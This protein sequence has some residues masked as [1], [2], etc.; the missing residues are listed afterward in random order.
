MSK[1]K[2]KIYMDCINIQ[3]KNTAGECLQDRQLASVI[4]FQKS[5]M[6]NEKSCMV[7]NFV[8]CCETAEQQ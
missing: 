8:K 4:V 1:I 7:I 6:P 2:H 3:S 5:E